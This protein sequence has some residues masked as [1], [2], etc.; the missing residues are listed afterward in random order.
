MELDDS[1]SDEERGKTTAELQKHLDNKFGAGLHHPAGFVERTDSGEC[2]MLL[3]ILAPKETGVSLPGRN[4]TTRTGIVKLLHDAFGLTIQSIYQ[5][6][7]NPRAWTFP[8]D[9]DGADRLRAGVFRLAPNLGFSLFSTYGSPPKKAWTYVT[10]ITANV[11]L[12]DMRKAIRGLPTVKSADLPKRVKTREGILT[13]KAVVRVAWNDIDLED[14]VT[15]NILNIIRGCYVRSFRVPGSLVTYELRSLPPCSCCGFLNHF[16]DACPYPA[17]I[18][19]APLLELTAPV[20]HPPP[21]AL[22]AGPAKAPRE[23]KT[24]KKPTDKKAKNDAP[25]GAPEKAKGKQ[26]E[27]VELPKADKVSIAL[28]YGEKQLINKNLSI[29][30]S[31]QTN[32]KKR[33]DRDDDDEQEVSSKTLSQ[34]YII[35]FIFLEPNP[36][37]FLLSAHHQE[38]EVTAG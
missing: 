22:V 27:T 1:S 24:V 33:K 29:Q 15:Q 4:L 28:P 32:A 18:A 12:D 20:D 30:P 9:S 3:L 36:R 17:S 21:S 14:N 11:A 25:K 5:P 35:N 19:S 13:E 6:T 26:K 37:G 7:N 8:I 31:A 2:H 16:V 38:E 23:K 34:H 10:P